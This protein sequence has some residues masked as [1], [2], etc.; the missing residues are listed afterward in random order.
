MTVL[1]DQRRRVGVE[2]RWRDTVIERHRIEVQP[3]R[4]VFE[5]TTS[6]ILGGVVEV[7]HMPTLRVRSD[8]EAVAPPLPTI[9]STSFA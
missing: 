1:V 4:G 5:D 6:E 9:S 7:V 8:H 2:A 3:F